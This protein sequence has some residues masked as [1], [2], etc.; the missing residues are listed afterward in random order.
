MKIEMLK[1]KKSKWFWRI[2]ANNGK[3]LAHSESYNSKQACRKTA[4]MLR[5]AR[6]LILKVL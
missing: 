6:I 2:K 3:I 4:G 5:G 1:N